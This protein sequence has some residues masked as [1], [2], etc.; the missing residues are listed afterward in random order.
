LGLRDEEEPTRQKWGQSLQTGEHRVEQ[1][2]AESL[3]LSSVYISAPRQLE[4]LNTARV[5]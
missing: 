1:R 4:K 3:S 2:A 5:A